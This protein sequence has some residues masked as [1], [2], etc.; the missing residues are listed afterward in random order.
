MIETYKI[1]K[2]FSKSLTSVGLSEALGQRIVAHVVDQ[3]DCYNHNYA[4][5]TSS[6]LNSTQ[7]LTIQ[8]FLSDYNFHIESQGHRGELYW[9]G[10]VP[11]WKK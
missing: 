7:L 5:S 2:D 3:L 4:I 9:Y 10:I 11:N 6:K 8:R 1:L